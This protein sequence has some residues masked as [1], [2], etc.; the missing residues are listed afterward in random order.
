MMEQL[1][2]YGMQ[3]GAFL[4]AT[5]LPS[6]TKSKS[7]LQKLFEKKLATLQ[8]S[9]IDFRPNSITPLLACKAVIG[10][11]VTRFI[12]VSIYRLYFHPLRK[13]PGPVLARI[14]NLY[15]LYFDVC[16]PSIPGQDLLDHY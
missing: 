15:S 14:T 13:F 9:D 3:T 4:Q 8:F 2:E 7:E 16:G 10:L 5:V 6:I 11:I 1:K 12:V